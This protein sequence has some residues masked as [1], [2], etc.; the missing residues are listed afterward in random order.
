MNPVNAKAG[1]VAGV[2]V[3]ALFLAGVAPAQPGRGP[4]GPVVVSPE[5]KSD[6]NV[7]F[8]LHAPKA[9]KV[10]VFT[11]DIPGGFAP[12]PMKRGKEG[13]WELTL[14]RVEPGTYR[15]LFNVDGKVYSE[16]EKMFARKHDYNLGVL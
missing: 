1:R 13:V 15:Y 3:A 4:K 7:T 2:L 16:H 6:R 14:A 8:R 11:T 10:G 12:R 9:E 5:V